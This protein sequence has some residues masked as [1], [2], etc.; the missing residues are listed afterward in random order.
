MANKLL[1]RLYSNAINVAVNVRSPVFFHT[2]CSGLTKIGTGK[3]VT[4]PLTSPDVVPSLWKVAR[5]L[6]C[7]SLPGPLVSVTSHAPVG[8][9]ALRCSLAPCWANTTVGA[10]ARATS[11]TNSRERIGNTMP[12]GCGRIRWVP[13]T[14]LTDRFALA[15]QS[16]GVE[17][18]GIT[19]LAEW[20][21]VE[22]VRS[23][24][25]AEEI[26]SFPRRTIEIMAARLAVVVWAGRPNAFLNCCVFVVATVAGNE[27]RHLLSDR[28]N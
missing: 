6:G 21:I 12:H 15:R 13:C 26:E 8:S 18:V 3:P 19:F 5:T 16:S 1:S 7:P 20:L 27:K 10:A 4:S 24:G 11:S 23:S 9:L 2:P 22:I 25:R 28:R 14:E 17:E